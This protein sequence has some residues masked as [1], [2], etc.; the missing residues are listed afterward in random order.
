MVTMDNKATRNTMMFSDGERL[1]NPVATPRTVLRSVRS[2][3]FPD[4]TTSIC[5]FVFEYTNESSPRCVTYTFSK[6]MILDQSLDVQIFNGDFIELANQIKA[7]FVKEI[8]A[9]ILY[10]QMLL[11]KQT[12]SFLSIRAAQLPLTHLALLNF[13][14]SLSL[15]KI[16]RILNRF[17]SRKRG[18]ILKSYVNTYGATSLRKP[19]RLIFFNCEDDEPAVNLSLDGASLNFAFNLTR[20]AQAH[21]ANLGKCQ[22]VAFKFESG[23]RIGKRIIAVSAFESWKASLLVT[24]QASLKEGIKSATDT[25][26]RV[27]NDL[28]MDCRHVLTNELDVRQLI[29]LLLIVHRFASDSISVYAFT[30]GR[31]VN[32]AAYVKRLLKL[33]GNAFGGSLDFEFVRFDSKYI[34]HDTVAS[35]KCA[36]NGAIHPLLERRGL[37]AGTVKQQAKSSVNA[38]ACVSPVKV[39]APFR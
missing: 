6:M 30:Q 2:R 33:L 31:I 37:L 16:A 7:C 22:F 11:A 39:A 15:A 34:L 10:L 3:N 36:A 4:S 5:S 29:L 9:L 13:Q 27:L 1:F 12:D 8:L 19:T 32:L 25:T 26:Q 14:L 18:K 35:I 24:L 17:T 23:L 38:I 28:R 21:R 20:Q